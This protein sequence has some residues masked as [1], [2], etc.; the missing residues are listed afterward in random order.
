MEKK[1]SNLKQLYGTFHFALILAVPVDKG[2]RLGYMFP[3]L[4]SP[5]HGDYFSGRSTVSS[6]VAEKSDPVAGI[7]YNY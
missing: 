3:A 2:G 6:D 5:L 7:K 4:H 1:K